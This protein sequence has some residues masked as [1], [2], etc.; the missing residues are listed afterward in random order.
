MSIEAINWALNHAPIPTDRKDASALAITLI[1]L[2]NHAGPDGT[3]AF[4]SVERLTTYTRLSRRTVQRAPL[5]GRAGPDP[6]GHPAL[7]RRPDRARRPPPQVYDLV[8]SAGMSTGSAPGR[9]DDAPLT[10]SGRQQSWNGGVKHDRTGRQHDAQNVRQPSTNPPR[11]ERTQ[12]ALG[13]A[14]G[15]QPVRRPTGRPCRSP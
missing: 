12:R 10:S 2:A 8:L 14:T 11:T 1:A 3:E 7:P 15:V 4:P 13:K 5:P 9:Q 6:Q